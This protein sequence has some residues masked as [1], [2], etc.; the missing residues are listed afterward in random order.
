MRVFV[1]HIQSVVSVGL[2]LF[3]FLSYNG[4]WD[5]Y[6][7]PIFASDKSMCFLI[8]F[9]FLFL[10]SRK[11]SLDCISVGISRITDSGASHTIGLCRFICVAFFRPSLSLTLTHSECVDER[12]LTGYLVLWHSTAHSE[13][14]PKREKSREKLGSLFGVLLQSALCVKTAN[15][16]V[17]W[18][19]EMWP[20][21]A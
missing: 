21:F 17:C 19:S 16:F 20:F 11:I 2:L 1:L 7:Q 14:Q 18:L 13:T 3:F 4:A 5:L 10:A 8:A 12:R 9:F 15:V 6:E